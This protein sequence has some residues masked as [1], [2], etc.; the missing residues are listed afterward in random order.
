MPKIS[1]R[2]SEY[3]NVLKM[4]KKPSWDEFSTTAKVAL[5]VMF[6]VG[7]VGFLVYLVME[8]LPGAFR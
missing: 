5:A 6:I 7:F 3:Y 2:L 8:V 1:D 4:A